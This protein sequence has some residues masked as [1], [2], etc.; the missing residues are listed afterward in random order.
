MKNAVY[1]AINKFGLLISEMMVIRYRKVYILYQ[2]CPPL[3]KCCVLL[4]CQSEL[5]SDIES[6]IVMVVTALIHLHCNI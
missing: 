2:V 3:V 6:S 5:F 1:K 4:V